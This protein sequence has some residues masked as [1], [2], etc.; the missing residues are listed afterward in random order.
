MRVGGIPIGGRLDRYVLGMFAASYLSAFFLVVGLF[1]LL[2]M[3]ANLDGYMDPG[4]DGQA[5]P[6]TDLL[7]FYGLQLPFLYLQMSPFVTLVAGLFT[8]ARLTQHCETVAALAAGIGLRRMFAPVIACGVLLALGM[9]GLREWA[10]DALGHQRDGLRDSLIER[11]EN[12]IYKDIWV[13]D[14][15][16]RPLHIGEF[17]PATEGMDGAEFRGLVGRFRE[18]GRT[19]AVSAER[20]VFESSPAP[21]KWLLTGGLRLE[22][23]GQEQRRVLLEVLGGDV[24]TPA[25]IDL[26]RK[27]RSHPLELSISE[28]SDLLERSPSD[29]QY[30]TI[31]HYHLSFPLAGIVLLLVG[32]P[33]ALGQERGRGIERIATGF[34]LCVLYFGFDFLVRTVGMQGQIGPVA[35]SW[36]LLTAFGGLGIVLYGSM[37]S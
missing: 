4:K 36:S 1:L 30:R 8:A 32:L 9:L 12:P 10:T 33:F 6:F 34:L 27:G 19:V 11:R 31:F 7:G 2:E 23:G 5:P 20:G 24:F 18:E 35:A 14:V 17:H 21:G 26:F 29:G 15:A 28:A 13:R 22:V 25:D 37:R 16:G 3:A